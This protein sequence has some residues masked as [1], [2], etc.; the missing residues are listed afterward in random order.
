[1]C[2]RTGSLDA[3]VY[4]SEEPAF[5][6]IT[7]VSRYH[8]SVRYQTD[9]LNI[10]EH[11]KKQVSAFS[12]SFLRFLHFSVS[13]WLYVP[14]QKAFSAIIASCRE[15]DIGQGL[16]DNELPLRVCTSRIIR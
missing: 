1:M 16:N 3:V 9:L 10:D 2:C 6:A 5:A 14:K 13:P 12:T 15:Y 7:T 8:T 4:R 11:P